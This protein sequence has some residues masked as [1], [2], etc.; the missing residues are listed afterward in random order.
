MTYR[1]G[2]TAPPLAGIPGGVVGVVQV[3]PSELYLRVAVEL[4]GTTK[5]PPVERITPALYPAPKDT[6]G[7]VQEVPSELTEAFTVPDPPTA[8]NTLPL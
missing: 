1:E 8:Q 7:L 6:E 5:L 4:S 2:L 3:T